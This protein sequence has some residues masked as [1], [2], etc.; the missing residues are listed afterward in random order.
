MRFVPLLLPWLELFTLIQLGVSTS[1]LTALA[2]VF[3]TLVIG[4]M[5]LRREGRSLMTQLNSGA[6][7]GARLLVEDMAV[8]MAGLLLM[9]PGLI[10]DVCALFVLVGPVRRRLFRALRGPQAV[11]DAENSAPRRPQT[12]EGEFR[13]VDS[14]D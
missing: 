6:P 13:R 9:I 14:D 3:V 4:M 7:L 1:A 10:T 12:I 2:W 8:A 5:L 11:S